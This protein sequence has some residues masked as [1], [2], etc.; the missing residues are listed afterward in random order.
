[1]LVKAVLS[2]MR[3]VPTMPTLAKLCRIHI[4]IRDLM[5]DLKEV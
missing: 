5:E 2:D 1:M 4:G 3:L